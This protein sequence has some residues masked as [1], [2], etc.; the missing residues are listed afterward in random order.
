MHPNRRGAASSADRRSQPAYS[1]AEAARYLSLPPATLRSWVLGRRY[2]TSTG[3]RRFTAVVQPASR[4]PLFMSF[5][6]LV[7][8]HVLRALRTD[9]HV[10]LRE[11]RQA[12]VYAEGQLGISNLL[13]RKDL[14]AGGSGLFLK[15]YGQLI[16]LSASGQLAMRRVLEDHLRRVEWDSSQFPTRLYPFVFGE[17]AQGR[18]PIAIDP[19]VAFGRPIVVTRGVTTAILV[20]RVDAGESVAALAADYDLSEAEIE[21]AILYERAA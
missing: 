1:V 20:D 19:A 6:N 21:Q 4:Q 9:H 7:E 5:W 17:A 15:R 13:L 2:D 12:L 11:V 8:C 14:L 18:P 3:T 10:P 16:D